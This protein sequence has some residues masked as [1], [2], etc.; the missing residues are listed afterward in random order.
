M[1][2]YKPISKV[3]FSHLRWANR[4]SF[5]FAGADALAP[6][7]A[8]E[9]SRACLRLPIAFIGHKTTYTPV[10]VQGLLRGENLFVVDG[11]WIAPYIPAGYRGYPFALAEG[12]DGQLHLCVDMDSGLVGE[13]ETFDQPFFDDAGEP[14]QAV[15]DVL[16]FLEQVHHGRAVTE[17]ICLALAA[18]GLIC[19]WPLKV[20]SADGERSIE[21]LFRVDEA[22]LNSL[23]AEA[24]HRVH[25]AGALAMAYCQLLSMSNIQELGMIIRKLEE[26]K[27]QPPS[28]G[29]NVD[30]DGFFKSEGRTGHGLT[31]DPG[32]ESLVIAIQEDEGDFDL[33]DL[34]ALGT[35]KH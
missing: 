9:V 29:N 5:D 34:S 24:L 20:Q 25:Q 12:G 17:R 11:K 4:R 21:G 33:S 14:T 31:T 8:K 22:R 35:R 19:P 13:D 3:H 15:K 2:K 28:P 30:L 18:E 16:N 32:D 7:T 6:L 26:R 27:H 23:D 1:P 10:V